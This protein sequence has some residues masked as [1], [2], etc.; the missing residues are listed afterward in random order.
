MFSWKFAAAPIDLY[1]S[2]PY[3]PVRGFV[4]R[5][6]RVQYCGRRVG[7]TLVSP[8]SLH[9]T[10]RLKS[11]PLYA[12]GT[13]PMSLMSRGLVYRRFTYEATNIRHL[14]I[15]I[16]TRHRRVNFCAPRAIRRPDNHAHPF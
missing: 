2:V 3:F 5:I 7:Q 10:D 4:R 14:I 9:T 11:V 15:G 12:R 1:S 16:H 6:M 13:L 8:P